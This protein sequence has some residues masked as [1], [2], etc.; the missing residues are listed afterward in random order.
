MPFY[1]AKG[2]LPEAYAAAE[3]IGC[4]LVLGT[5]DWDGVRQWANRWALMTHRATGVERYGAQARFCWACS[6]SADWFQN[7]RE[8]I[9][10]AI[11]RLLKP[12]IATRAPW[13]NLMAQAHDLNGARNFPLT[14]AEVTEIVRIE[15]YFA[16]P[17]PPRG[18]RHG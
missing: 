8:D 18:I 11:K 15:V 2:D 9:V 16:I 1:A 4:Q 14:E 7:Q 12:M 3:R 6:D 10:F 5:I 13:N 17:P